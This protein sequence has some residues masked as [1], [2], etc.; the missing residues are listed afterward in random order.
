MLFKGIEEHREVLS[1][2]HEWIDFKTWI[3]LARNFEQCGGDLFQAGMSFPTTLKLPFQFMI[4]R[5]ASPSVIHKKFPE[6]FAKT[7]TSLIH[8]SGDIN[9]KRGIWN[10][11][12]TPDR[13]KDYTTQVCDMYRGCSFATG[14]LKRLRN[15]RIEEVACA[16][17]SES[18]F[19]H[20]RL[21]WAPVP[22]IFNSIQNFFLFRKTQ[23]D[24]LEYMEDTHNDLQTQ[25]DQVK[26]LNEQLTIAFRKQSEQ[27]E[28]FLLVLASAIESKDEYTGGHVER[29][30]KYSRDLAEKCNIDPERRRNIYLGA[31]V[32]DVGKI[33]VRDAVL[34]KPDKLSLVEM[35]HMQTHT[36]IGKKL[37][38]KIENIE[39]ATQIAFGHQ[40]KY[41]GTGYPLGL[42]GDAIPIEARI[43]CIADVWDAITTDRP[44][45]KA[46]TVKAAI[47]TM[48][49]ERG[50]SFDPELFDKFMDEKDK[51][52]LRYLDKEKLKELYA[53]E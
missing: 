33:G 7:V 27:L 5:A 49:E 47:A 38:S 44:Y 28:S 2:V 32:H 29:V 36:T 13:K 22:S 12:F 19:C 20:Y 18:P 11:L 42:S 21:T 48:H 53:D 30:A 24:I 10:I 4:L 37:L 31:I 43:V 9:E 50:K 46:M 34:N 26:K 3:H 39:T 35:Q 51:L 23:N 14:Q 45:R 8:I 40:E 41:N 25:F 1:N 15:L 6:Q 16:A 17:R 52:H